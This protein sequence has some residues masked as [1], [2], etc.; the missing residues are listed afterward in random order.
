MSRKIILLLAA[1]LIGTLAF[2]TA[3]NKNKGK[4]TKAAEEA[5]ILVEEQNTPEILAKKYFTATTLESI[6]AWEP[7][8]APDYAE[9]LNGQKIGGLEIFPLL[10]KFSTLV[11]IEDP[12]AFTTELINIFNDDQLWKFMLT[13]MGAA[14]PGQVSEEDLQALRNM[15]LSAFRQ[16]NTDQKRMMMAKMKE[17]INDMMENR[18]K[19]FKEVKITGTKIEGD[20]AVIAAEAN[21][22]GETDPEVAAILGNKV[23]YEITMKMIDGKWK[24]Q[25]FKTNFNQ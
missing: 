13:A 9:Y 7:D 17:S 14:A 20:T 25:T 10:K 11:K 16:M 4:K 1:A 24:Y 12:D 8:C 2:T 22:P 21:V 6:L 23:G 18:T 3:C 15:M 19:F 5:E